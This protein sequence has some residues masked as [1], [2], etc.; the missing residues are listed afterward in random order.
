MKLYYFP[1][2]PN[3]RKILAVIAHLGI[4]DIELHLVNLAKGEQRGAEFLR[5]NPMGK[6]PVLVDGDLVLWESN[7]IAQYLCERHGPSGFYPDDPRIR[8]DIARWMFWEA[9]SFSKACDVFTNENVRKPMLGIGTPDPAKLAE[10][11]EKF[12]PL[13]RVLDAALA[14]Q[15]YLAGGEPTL[16]DFVVA[17]M[18]TYL[19]RGKFPVADYPRLLGWWRRMNAVDAWR[20]SMPGPALPA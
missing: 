15:E 19:E 16:A 10:G 1:P 6:I 5:V 14:R 17:A 9:G 18:L 8:A 4:N 13:A 12:H 2:S 7:A 3:A 20:D 11:E